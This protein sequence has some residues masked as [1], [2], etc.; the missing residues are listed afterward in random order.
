[1]SYNFVLLKEEL[2]RASVQPP[3]EIEKIL[4]AINEVNDKYIPPDIKKKIEQLYGLS[5]YRI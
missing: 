4:A 1:M 2:K 3:T 5:L